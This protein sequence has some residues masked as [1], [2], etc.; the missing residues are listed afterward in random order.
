MKTNERS[1]FIK[2]N[3]YLPFLGAKLSCSRR[4]FSFIK[5]SKMKTYCTLQNPNIAFHISRLLQY[6]M[7]EI[8]FSYIY[9]CICRVQRAINLN[10]HYGIYSLNINSH[11][12]Q[13]EKNWISFLKYFIC[14][15][16]S[17][18]A[19]LPSRCHACKQENTTCNK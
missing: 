5:F 12:L 3:I 14:F 19:Y 15:Q 9:N 17:H 2:E 6:I 8:F 10:N 11:E 7:G 18:V 16:Y 4:N 1:G 13:K